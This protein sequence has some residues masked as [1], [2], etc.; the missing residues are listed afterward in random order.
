[1]S[2]GKG[3]F[4][5]SAKGSFIESA[6]GARG[7]KI[8]GVAVLSGVGANDRYIASLNPAT[9][10]KIWEVSAGGLSGS[11]TKWLVFNSSFQ[12]FSGAVGS[13]TNS[14]IKRR[15]MVD[16]SVEATLT[17]YLRNNMSPI[18]NDIVF[19]S[20]DP[21]I[22]FSQSRV[23]PAL[24][25]TFVWQ[26]DTPN[27]SQMS[28]CVTDAAGNSYFVK[29]TAFS[30]DVS[31]VEIQRWA[32]DKNGNLLWEVFQ[33]TPNGADGY[34]HSP[35]SGALE[36]DDNYIYVLLVDIIFPGVFPFADRLLAVYRIN[37]NTG[38]LFDTRATAFLDTADSNPGAQYR[39]PRLINGSLYVPLRRRT[40][41]YN[42]IAKVNLSMV[43]TASIDMGSTALIYTIDALPA[44]SVGTGDILAVG[45]TSTTWPGSLGARANCWRISSDL[46]TIRWGVQVGEDTFNG[47]QGISSVHSSHT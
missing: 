1:M 32:L 25:G 38:A 19:S 39:K 17:G 21:T 16:G 30:N 46:S 10:D 31:L 33:T 42:S 29:I 36:V 45:N 7:W 23:T 47:I 40:S 4:G 13:G 44:D 18:G 34:T 28:D 37:K 9:G 20:D 15:S 27:L 26:Y 3:A 35:V 43:Q 14:H 12:L 5:Q 6:M 11:A 8:G 41:G 2:I 22:G 24:D